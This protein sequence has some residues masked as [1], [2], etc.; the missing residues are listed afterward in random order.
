MLPVITSYSIHY[1]KLYEVLAYVS[2]SAAVAKSGLMLGLGE[3]PDE[4]EEALL[5]LFHADVKVVTLG[6][7]LRPSNQHYPVK[8][9]IRPE[10]FARLKAIG[11]K[12][13][14]RYVES[15]PQ[16]RSSYHAEQHVNA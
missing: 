13:G 15:G 10:E 12:M 14:F 1:T 5:D 2:Q 7:Y 9:Y 16:V 3:T 8:E 4:V 11:L 6:Q